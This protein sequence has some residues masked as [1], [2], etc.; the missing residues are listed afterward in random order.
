MIRGEVSQI[1]QLMA[2]RPQT[3]L[4]TGDPQRFGAHLA[5][6]RGRAEAV[7]GADQ[8]DGLTGRQM[9]LLPQERADRQPN[10]AP[11]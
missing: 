5:A 9:E 6:G 4:D 10:G 3:P 7:R 11:D 1:A 8:G 2:E